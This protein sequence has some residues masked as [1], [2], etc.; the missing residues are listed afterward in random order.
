[1]YGG[2]GGGGGAALDGITFSGKGGDGSQGIV[3]VTT[4]F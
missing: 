4:Y 3:I 1:L 2:G